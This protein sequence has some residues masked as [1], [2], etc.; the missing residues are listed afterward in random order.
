MDRM[1]ERDR[2]GLHQQAQSGLIDEVLRDRMSDEREIAA[3]AHA[4]GLRKASRYFP[5]TVRVR[6]QPTGADPLARQRRNVALLDAVAHAV[7]ASG[8]TGLFATR[9]D[10]EVGAVIA[11]SSS[12]AGG[13]DKTWN[14]LGDGVNREVMRID[15]VQHSV[16]AVGTPADA[17]HRCGARTGRVRPRRGGGAGDG[18]AG[19][20]VLPRIRR[21]V[22]RVDLAVA[23]RSAGAGASPRPN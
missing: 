1:I 17:R 23:G 20:A 16:L 19:P 13:A 7:N 2:T 14:A 6:Y 21:A 4:L 11:L 12:R 22:A 3:R 18:R 10:G 5:V 8:H 15:G 9:S